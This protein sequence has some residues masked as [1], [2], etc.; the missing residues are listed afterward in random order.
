MTINQEHFT[1]YKSLFPVLRTQTTR[2]LQLFHTYLM[3]SGFALE[4]LLKGILVAR[5]PTLTDKIVSKKIKHHKLEDLFKLVG[6]EIDETES[7]M[8]E[9]LTESIIWAGRYPIPLLKDDMVLRKRT[10]GYTD[11]GGYW[12]KAQD[13]PG[14]NE[15]IEQLWSRLLSVVEKE[16]NIKPGSSPIF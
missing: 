3:L 13:W 5:E 8:V 10:L 16:P 9:R 14:D 2:H 11:Q 7:V 4:N 12:E 15:L 6:I 1:T